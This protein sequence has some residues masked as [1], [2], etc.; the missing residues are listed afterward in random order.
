[1]KKKQKYLTPSNID[2]IVSGFFEHIRDNWDFYKDNLP[3]LR[4]TMMVYNE[5]AY[6]I[7]FLPENKNYR[8]EFNPK[9]PLIED[10]EKIFGNAYTEEIGRLIYD[11]WPLRKEFKGW[12]GYEEPTAITIK[13]LRKRYLKMMKD[14]LIDSKPEEK[15]FDKYIDDVIASGYK[16]IENDKIVKL[17][18]SGT[19][20]SYYKGF[21]TVTEFQ[22]QKEFLDSVRNHPHIRYGI[23]LM[24]QCYAFYKSRNRKVEKLQRQLQHIKSVKSIKKTLQIIDRIRVIEKQEWKPKTEWRK[25]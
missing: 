12:E 25:K 11:A 3:H 5:F 14:L 8:I 6:G 17:C 19:P 18:P 20:D 23:Q 16:K 2:A 13:A 9:D 10:V 7:R 15:S 24:E 4:K 1:M 21:T 22:A